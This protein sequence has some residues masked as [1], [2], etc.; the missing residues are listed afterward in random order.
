M[1]GN[2]VG[3]LEP[4]DDAR[5]AYESLAEL[6]RSPFCERRIEPHA[7]DRDRAVENRIERLIDRAKSTRRKTLHDVVAPSRNMVLGVE[8][9]RTRRRRLAFRI[10]GICLSF[11]SQNRGKNRADPAP[12]CSSTERFEFS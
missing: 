9:V 5:L 1:N 7:F 11:H 8:T 4:R 10:W 12:R 6:V 2:D 3:V